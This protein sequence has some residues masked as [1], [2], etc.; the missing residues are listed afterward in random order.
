VT[1]QFVKHMS[2]SIHPLQRR[3]VLLAGLGFGL[4]VGLCACANQPVQQNVKASRGTMPSA[5]IDMGS[6]AAV[7]ATRIARRVLTSPNPNVAWSVGIKQGAQLFAAA[8]AEDSI[9]LSQSLFDLCENDGQIAAILAHRVACYTPDATPALK[10]KL[11]APLNSGPFAAPISTMYAQADVSAIRALAKAGYDPRD[12]RA[13]WQRIGLA[14]NSVDP[15]HE[16]RL[17]SMTQELH[18]LGYQ[19]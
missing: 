5:E 15:S 13:I 10:T 1:V 19:V 12:G 11:L 17:N 14:S 4:S 9:I 3:D 6:A 8:V 2:V 16:L 7:R 18:K